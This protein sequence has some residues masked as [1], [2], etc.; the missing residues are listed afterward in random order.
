MALWPT[1]VHPLGWARSTPRLG[2]AGSLLPQPAS[3]SG[4]T[5]NCS[6]PCTS[7]VKALP[8]PSRPEMASR[9]LGTVPQVRAQLA[10][11]PGPHPSAQ[12]SHLCLGQPPAPW[13]GRTPTPN[14]DG[15]P[16]KRPLTCG[17]DTG[18]RCT[19]A[20]APCPVAVAVPGPAA[21]CGLWRQLAA[22]ALGEDGA[23]WGA[24]AGAGAC[25][26]YCPTDPGA[27]AGGGGGQ[28]A[29]S[30]PP[31]G[32]E[33]AARGTSARGPRGGQSRPACAQA[34]PRSPTCRLAENW[35]MAVTGAVNR[36][37]ARLRPEPRRKAPWAAGWR[38]SGEQRA[39]G[40]GPSPYTPSPRKAPTTSSPQLHTG[41]QWAGQRA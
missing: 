38:D 1:S 33:V 15:G 24:G 7:T 11:R 32:T 14:A 6:R 12:R 29:P 10:R 2:D 5:C 9:D 13:A 25:G 3:P 40:P 23:E 8:L 17:G 22:A 4:L 27:A 21:P 34:R 16:R 20:P 37:E 19:R 30:G 41:P 35:K 39:A 26:A 28:G 36:P 31:A 18:T